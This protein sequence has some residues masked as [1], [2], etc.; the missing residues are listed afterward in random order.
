MTFPTIV[1]GGLIVFFAVVTVAV[2]VPGLIW[3][4][5]QT[6]IAHEYT[7]QQESGRVLFY[8]NGCNYCHTQYVRADDTSMGPVSDGGNYVFD[9]PLILGSERTGPDLSYV[10]HKR[11]AQWEV[12]HLKDPRKYSAHVDHCPTL[13]F[14]RHDQLARYR[15]FPCSPGATGWPAERMIL[16]PDAYAEAS[17][18]W[19]RT[20]IQVSD[21][22]QG[23]D[24]WN[25]L[26]LLDGK[27]DLYRPLPD[28][29][30]LRRQR[31][32]QLRPVADGDAGGFLQEPFRN[33]RGERVVLARGP[34]GCRAR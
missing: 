14:C 25:A 17:D 6:T 15:G 33:M 13:A 3:D 30:R 16:P 22:D 26:D 19:G 29:P 23:W 32:G 34:R 1:I 12:E 2:F 20:L 24:T 21:S 8:S 10:G 27:A 11:S 7:A 31:P 4:P 18:P 9:D 5:Q 28:V